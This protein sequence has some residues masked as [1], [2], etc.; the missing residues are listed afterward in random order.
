MD[1]VIVNSEELWRVVE[2]P[3]FEARLEGWSEKNHDEIVGMG[4]EDVYHYFVKKYGLKESRESFLA[5]CEEVALDIYDRRASLAEGLIPFLEEARL[6]KIPLGLA[7]SS[8]RRWI[9]RVLNRFELARYFSSVLSAEDVQNQ[10]KPDPALYLASARNLRVS[11]AEAW[12]IEDS[13]VGVRSAKSAGFFCLGFR[14]RSNAAQDLSLA[15][16]EIKSF[17]ELRGLLLNRS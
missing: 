11:P 16:E 14:S 8:P 9:A 17:K 1:G 2:T 3:I 7:S 6:A 4:V 13:S 10:T 5:A 12:A 15:D